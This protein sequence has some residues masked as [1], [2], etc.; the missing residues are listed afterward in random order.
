MEKI[1]LSL[2]GDGIDDGVVLDDIV[3]VV[4]L[5]VYLRRRRCGGGETSPSGELRE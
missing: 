3:G 4:P 1:L 2:R 5:L